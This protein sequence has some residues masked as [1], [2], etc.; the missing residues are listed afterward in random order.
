MLDD[1]D[2]VVI[3]CKKFDLGIGKGAFGIYGMK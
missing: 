2:G 1:Y 3:W